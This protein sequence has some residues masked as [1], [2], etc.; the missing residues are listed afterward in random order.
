MKGLSESAGGG[1][2][3]LTRPVVGDKWTFRFK[4]RVDGFEQAGIVSREV[5]EIEGDY[6]WELFKTSSRPE[7]VWEKFDL[8]LRF[9]VERRAYS[10]STPSKRGE[11]TFD[12]TKSD[13]LIQ[14]P[15]SVGKSYKAKI[16]FSNKFGN[17]YIDYTAN[18][19]ALEKI[20]VEAGEFEVYKIVLKGRWVNTSAGGSDLSER[21]EWY[22]PRAKVTVRSELNSWSQG[23]VNP[24]NT[25]ELSEIKLVR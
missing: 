14:H 20:K 18:V 6:A 4:D 15:L 21:T 12:N 13:P 10:E 17:G 22:A 19:E 25:F 16:I 23:R 2:E 8:K 1:P 9:L 3:R 7:P 24:Y 11:V 5:V